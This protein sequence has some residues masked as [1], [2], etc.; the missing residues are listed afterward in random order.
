MHNQVAIELDQ[1]VDS[2]SPTLVFD[3][4][5]YT[6]EQLRY[7]TNTVR[8]LD[9]ESSQCRTM[10]RVSIVMHLHQKEAQ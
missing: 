1:V 7:L 5:I 8:F 6:H 9:Q 3:Q 4:S 10:K 2:G